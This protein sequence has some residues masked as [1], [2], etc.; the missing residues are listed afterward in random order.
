MSEQVARGSRLT[1]IDSIVGNMML[2][3]ARAHADR[4]A[5]TASQS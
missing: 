3:T 1:A 5:I 4:Q 2:G